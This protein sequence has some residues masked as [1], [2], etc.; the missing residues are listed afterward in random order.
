MSSNIMNYIP[1]IMN[2]VAG[3]LSRIEG[4][5]G[6]ITSKLLRAEV[7][8]LKG[9]WASEVINVAL[10]ALGREAAVSGM[11]ASPAQ[12]SALVKMAQKNNEPI[13]GK[14]KVMRE[15]RKQETTK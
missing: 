11:V 5:E 9:Q 2:N 15:A 12:V 1:E 4:Q 7:E 8:R 10:I 6:K 3:V 13:I 14:I